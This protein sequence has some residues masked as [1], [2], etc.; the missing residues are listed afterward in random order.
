[1]GKHRMKGLTHLEHLYQVVVSG[2]PADFPPLNTLDATPNNLPVQLTSFIGR[3]DALRAVESLL[4]EHRLVTL[5]GP[6]G[7][8]KTRLALKVAEEVQDSYPH[9]VWL[10]ELAPLA[11]PALVPQAVAL[12]LG[13]RPEA[14]RPLKDMLASYL[15]PRSLLL[16]LDNCEHLVDSC[17]ELADWLLHTCPQLH[18]LASSRESLNIVGEAC[19]VVPSMDTPIR[20]ACRRWKR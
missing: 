11:D 18:I 8:G 3:A 4:K 7:C 12:A 17:A 20:A 9:G 6:G 2:L 15:R 16:L 1:M 13:L 5:T 10:T 14:E 19:F